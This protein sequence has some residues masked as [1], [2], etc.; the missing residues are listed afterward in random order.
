MT[1]RR[2]F[3][4]KSTLASAALMTPIP[5]DLL[6]NLQVGPAKAPELYLFSKH[7][8]FLDY[9]EMSR[10]TKEIGF[11]GLDLTVRPKGHV[12]PANVTTDLP[13]ATEAMEAAG[14]KTKL[15]CTSVRD[16]TDPVQYNVLKTASELGYQHFRTGWYK[17]DITQD[18]LAVVA[19]AKG[20]RSSV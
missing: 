15:F 5:T 13:R 17:Y 3:I 6:S 2:D 8:Q 14:L 12:L 4:K 9:E 11:D 1:T 19:K 16:I 10:V 20:A 18:I 7:L